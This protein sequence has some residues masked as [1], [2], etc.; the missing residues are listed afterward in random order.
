[1]FTCWTKSFCVL[2]CYY[3]KTFLKNQ[4]TSSED[5]LVTFSP[6]IDMEYVIAILALAAV[7]YS[8]CGINFL[9][10]KLVQE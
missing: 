10:T 2:L 3:S 4:A 9:N 1:M 6:R 8:W 5:V 7:G